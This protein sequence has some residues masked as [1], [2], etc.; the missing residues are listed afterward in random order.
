M[1]PQ[2][3]SKR[4]V[5]RAAGLFFWAVALLLTPVPT[6]LAS[7][8]ELRFAEGLEAYDAG[9]FETAF[10]VWRPLAEAGH[11]DAQVSLAELYLNGLGVAADPVAGVAWYRRAAAAGD[12][13]AQLNLGDFYARGFLVGRDLAEAF[14]WLELAARQGKTWAAARRDEITPRLTPA[15]RAE[16]Q[17][18]VA[19][20]RLSE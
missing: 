2:A 13:V 10:R 5:A 16:A 11:L 14:A 8:A 1:L 20:Y 3:C 17:E 15:E 7:D 18:R 4:P 12:P 6:A 19:R 9:N